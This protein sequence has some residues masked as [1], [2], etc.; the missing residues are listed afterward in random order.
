M[1]LNW[2]SRDRMDTATL[3]EPCHTMLLD[4]EE[5]NDLALGHRRHVQSSEI[6]PQSK[7]NRPRYYN[8]PLDRE[9]RNMGTKLS[10][11]SVR[12]CRSSDWCSASSSCPRV[13]AAAHINHHLVP[14]L[15]IVSWHQLGLVAIPVVAPITAL[16]WYHRGNSSAHIH[17]AGTRSTKT[18]TLCKYDKPMAFDMV[19][20]ASTNCLFQPDPTVAPDRKAQLPWFENSN[21]YSDDYSLRFNLKT[22]PIHKV[23]QLQSWINSLVVLPQVV[24][25]GVLETPPND[26][27]LILKS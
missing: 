20:L 7:P 10:T 5:S 4:S 13:Y 1:R 9:K 19:Y 8:R 18:T 6:C 14:T 27:G 15:V 3:I 26:A 16:T 17:H 25:D 23:T 22:R 24:A 2:K 11:I 21:A 12:L